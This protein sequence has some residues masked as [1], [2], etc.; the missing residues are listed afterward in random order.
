[1][2]VAVAMAVTMTVAVLILGIVGAMTP[3]LEGASDRV[4]CRGAALSL[5][6]I[7]AITPAIIQ[8]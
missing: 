4:A 7:L 5:P 8:L 6:I 2:A 1:M 3:V